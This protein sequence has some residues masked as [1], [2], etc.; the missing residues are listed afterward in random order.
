M[1]KISLTIEDIFNVPTSEIFNPDIFKPV[2]SVL[3]DSRNMVKDSLFIAIKGNR[4]DG[5]NFLQDA[6][7]N[8]A[9]AVVINR[10]EYK[11]FED[12]YIPIVTVKDT[13]K[14]LGDIAKIWRNKLSGRTKIISI[15][16]SAGKTSTKE[17]IALLLNEKYSVNKTVGNNN[18]HIGVPLTIFNT[19]EKH[20]VLVLEHGT[21]H[22]GEIEYT[23]EIA[24]PDFALITNIGDSHLEFFKNRRGVLEEKEAL[25]RITKEQNGF[26]FVNNDDS[27]LKKSYK[28]YKNRITFGFSF[29][30]GSVVNVQGKLAGYT[31]EGRPIIEVSYK[32]KKIN[33][34]LPLYGKQNASNYLAA[35]T[36]GLKL[37]LTKKQIE[38]GTKKLIAVDKR[39]NVKKFKDFILVDDTYNA[40][41]E[42]MKYALQ[43]LSKF[44]SYKRKIAVLGDMFELGKEEIDLHIKLA[45]FVFNNKITE[46]YTIGKR[47]KNL[48]D[49]IDGAKIIKKHFG[50]RDNLKFFL[51]NMDI[52]NS[53]VLVKGSRGMKM[54]EFVDILE[55]KLL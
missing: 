43:F 29:D 7:N 45:S 23:S 21:N 15:T 5:H 8:G 32:N 14:A 39:L 25:F 17:M 6:I 4:F 55:T 10:K 44:K 13:K 24:K 36:V 51:R 18:N 11:K 48:S 49:M 30:K 40:N 1:K 12:I 37:G 52:S 38:S 47:M 3:I 35:V 34:A 16:G 41:P 46:V 26:L 33:Q 42:S 27:L 28:D 19:N 20:N 2:T 31:D 9:S 53:V 54:E 22:F 50:R